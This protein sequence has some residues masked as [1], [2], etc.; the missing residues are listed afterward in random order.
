MTVSNA[1]NS[2]KSGSEFGPNSDYKLLDPL[3]NGLEYRGI[4]CRVCFT[5]L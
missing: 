5:S 1:F 3:I 2:V 4:K